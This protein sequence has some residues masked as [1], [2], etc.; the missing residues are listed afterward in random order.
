M[1]TI[2]LRVSA[3]TYTRTSGG[4]GLPGSAFG[5]PSVAFLNSPTGTGI[6]SG[7]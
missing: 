3:L 7:W 2:W 5:A 1:P 4:A 6:E